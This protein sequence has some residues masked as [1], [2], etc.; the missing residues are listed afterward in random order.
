MDVCISYTSNDIS[1]T[2]TV[3]TINYASQPFSGSIT[4]NAAGNTIDCGIGDT[5]CSN[6][7][8]KI[9]LIERGEID[10]SLK[11]E[12]CQAG[13]GIGAIIYNN[14]DGNLNGT[15]G[16]IFSGTI[17]AI[18]ITKADGASLKA[19]I[20][21]SASLTVVE[22]ISQSIS[23]GA[24]FLGDKWLLTASHCVEGRS[25]QKLK[26]NVGEYNLSN[27]AENIKA[28][29]RIY[30]H[31]DYEL[32]IELD[33]DIALIELVDSVDNPAITL[34]DSAATEQFSI[35]NSTVT[36]VG[37]GGREGYA[38][39]GGPT[40]D[41]PDL[42][43]QVDL[44]LLTNSECKDI[45]AESSTESFVGTYS[46]ND[47]GITNAMICAFIPSGGKSA[48]QGDSG[49][50]LMINTNEGWQQIGIVS[51]GIGCAAEGFPD[52][53]TRTA[54]FSDWVN[55]ITQGIAIDQR[56]DFTTQP[57]NQTQ[58]ATLDIVNNSELSANLTF[59]IDGNTNFTIVNDDCNS[60]AAGETCLLQ[61]SYKADGVG[62]HTANITIDSDNSEIATSSAKIF[63]QSIALAGN[64]QVQLSS[65]DNALTWYSGGN[66]AWLLD[67]SE[68]AII[69][70]DINN[71]QE[72]IVM[73]TVSGEGT[74]SFEWS[75][76]SEE[77]TI[78]PENPDDA[79]YLYVDDELVNFISG[80]IDYESETV[81]LTAGEHKI[82]W[83]YE[84]DSI[85]SAGKDNARI[86][87][88]TFTPVNAITPTS[89]SSGGSISWLSLIFMAI[90]SLRRK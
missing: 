8:E 74:L 49:G 56:F 72:S 6:A 13:G 15:L 84:K 19:N 66:S 34:V 41:F 81:R 58:S 27:G 36:V 17:P 76:S 79:L 26:V 48:C 85:I 82:T 10:F 31:A 22:Y 80:D 25:P 9:C 7:S 51:W 16:K 54:F 20:G 33:N 39:D 32:N 60:I 52:V 75:V 78:S 40:S 3:D 69:S 11:V 50:P 77:N 37:W 83:I 89:S 43:L 21:T 90:I 68:A 63:A 86:R 23:C 65:T 12:N 5:P 35:D 70:G 62:K 18:S 46:A 71:N 88:V 57:E 47:V 55:G 73:V 59:E 29:K 44:E 28:V 64:I 30:M 53:Y 42:L 2:L 87:N 45:L 24:S 1:A 61:I 38:P 67:N 14:V 4:G